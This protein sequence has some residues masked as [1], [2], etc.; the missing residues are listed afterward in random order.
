MGDVI[1]L[2]HIIQAKRARQQRTSVAITNEASAMMVR[3]GATVLF[4][5]FALSFAIS[6][7]LLGF[8]NR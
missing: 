4:C 5:T 8:W 3:D 2:R 7:F 1:D 6:A